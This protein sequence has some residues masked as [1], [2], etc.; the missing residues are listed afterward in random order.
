VAWLNAHVQLAPGPAGAEDH[1]VFGPRAT[2][3]PLRPWPA[4]HS[5]GAEPLNTRARPIGQAYQQ[6]PG[7][8][9]SPGRSPR[10]ADG[11]RRTPSRHAVAHSCGDYSCGH[12]SWVYA[13]SR[14]QDQ[15]MG[16]SEHLHS[17]V[18]SR[19]VQ[20]CLGK[21]R[22]GL[23]PHD[24]EP[25]TGTAVG[26]R[27]VPTGPRFTANSGSSARTPRATALK[28]RGSHLRRECVPIHP[29]AARQRHDHLRGLDRPAR[30]GSAPPASVRTGRRAEHRRPGLR[31]H[32]FPVRPRRSAGTAGGDQFQHRWG[33][34]PVGH[35]F[36]EQGW[37]EWPPLR[38]SV[39]NLGTDPIPRTET[40]IV[41]GCR[42]GGEVAAPRASRLGSRRSAPVSRES[43][44][45]NRPFRP[46]PVSLP[47]HT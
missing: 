21:R 37:Q 40:V 14:W 46:P 19:P 27:G 26:Q 31:V 25:G 22:L 4:G 8:R 45:W 38:R 12:H 47:K 43:S 20:P 18:Q 11:P 44:P 3:A 23:D 28:A 30:G 15:R 5:Q 42:R 35:G 13:P 36:A 9:R 29:R 17:D 16:I 1:Q 2:G 10:I 34:L 7:N 32:R 24:S 6:G 33:C 41:G 39:P